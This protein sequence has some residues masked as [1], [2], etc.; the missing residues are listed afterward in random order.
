MLMYWKPCRARPVEIIS[1]AAAFTLSASTLS[2]QT[3]QE[4][5]P[6]GGVCASLCAPPMMVRSRRA[7]PCGPRTVSCTRVVPAF[8][9]DPEMMPVFGSSVRPAGRPW[10]A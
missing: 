7:V 10:A 8:R 9:K 5:Q 3:F 6:I 1:S 2:A 4:F